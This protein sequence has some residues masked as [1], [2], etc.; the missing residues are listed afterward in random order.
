MPRS[1]AHDSPRPKTALANLQRLGI[2]Q[3]LHVI[4]IAVTALAVGL[5]EAAFLVIAS[6]TALAI[7]SDQDVVQIT[8]G[9]DVT[10]LEAIGVAALAAVVRL[11]AGLLGVRAS[12][13]LAYRVSADLRARLTDRFIDADWS[14][15]RAK[16]AGTLQLLLVQ[17]PEQVAG[18][19]VNI[20]ASLGAGLSLAAM[21]I[22]AVVV[23]PA[24]TVIVIGTLVVLMFVLA[25]LR[26]EVGKRTRAAIEHQTRFADSVAELGSLTLEVRAFGREEQAKTHLD[27][28]VTSHLRAQW[29]TNI[30]LNSVLPVYVTLGYL[31]MLLALAAVT[32]VSSTQLTSV[33]AVML[34]MLR[35]LGYGQQLQNS[36]ASLAQV[37]PLLDHIDDAIESLTPRPQHSE[38]QSIDTLGAIELRDVTYR[39]PSNTEPALRDISLR[40]E[41][42]QTVGLVGPSG[43]GKSTLVQVLLGLI[44]PSSGAVSVGGVP[45]QTIARSI[46]TSLVSLVPQNAELLSGTIADNLAF[47]RPDV[48]TEAMRRACEAAHVWSEIEQF[49]DGLATRLGADGRQLSGG[50]RQR[51]AIARALVGA[52]QMIILDEPTSALDVDAETAIR[53]ALASLKGRVTIVVIAHRAST[54]TACDRIAVMNEGRIEAFGPPS[55]LREVSAFYQRMLDGPAA[56]E[57]P[58]PPM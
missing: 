5:L 15:Q 3:P 8:R 27:A 53:E 25:P 28:L 56:S 17:Y 55:E 22:A 51:L 24:S 35:S 57:A 13:G 34:I 11:V 21:L 30:V 42:G 19:L 10:V 41:P 37:G 26:K 16:P 1:V 36:A 9:F 58:A 50:Q 54:L 7:A 44:E 2:E 33:G 6:R 39:Y 46:W 31:A 12:V 40:I 14:A 52:P 47:F 23:D 48:S 18:L 49:P 45:L 32:D 20:A 38:A 29:R 43:G 4:A